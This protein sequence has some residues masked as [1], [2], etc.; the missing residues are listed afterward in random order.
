MNLYDSTGSLETLS[1]KKTPKL[2]KK[3]GSVPVSPND[4]S[5]STV[6]INLPFKKD[7][8]WYLCK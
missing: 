7:I 2:E 4:S 5:D 3:Y 1:S 8:L 6:K